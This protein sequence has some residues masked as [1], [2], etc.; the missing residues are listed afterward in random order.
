MNDKTA[1]LA[2]ESLIIAP[3]DLDAIIIDN[4][5]EISIT[6]TNLQKALMTS[7][8]ATPT[9]HEANIGWRGRFP[10]SSCR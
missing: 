8:L 5:G 10:L 3:L 2:K 1:D 6:H 9:C 4:H 7:F